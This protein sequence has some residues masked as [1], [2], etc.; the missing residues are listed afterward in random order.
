MVSGDAV[1]YS[2]VHGRSHQCVAHHPLDA[3]DEVEYERRSLLSY[4]PQEE[5]HRRTGI[6]Y[7]R[8]RDGQFAVGQTQHGS[9]VSVVVWMV[10]RPVSGVLSTLQKESWAAIHLCDLPRGGLVTETGGPLVPVF[11]L[12]PGG[13]YRATLVTQGAGALLPH[14][15]ILT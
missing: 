1:V 4:A 15:F 11:D 9:F 3:E 7:A 6:G 8:F 5:P 14:R 2:A 10:S 12:A 13:V